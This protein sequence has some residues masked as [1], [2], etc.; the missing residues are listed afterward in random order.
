VGEHDD[1]LDRVTAIARRHGVAPEQV[2]EVAGGVANRGFVL[3]DALFLRV[4]RPG[5]EDDLRKEAGVVPVA[6]AAGVLTPA[7]LEY[8]DTRDAPYVVMERVHG[9]EPTEAPDG[10]AEQL[11]RLHL[12]E[13]T[14]IPGVPQ[15]D[16]DDPWRT[17]DDLAERGYLD[18]GTA[19]WL[20]G[21]FTRLA[22]RFDRNEAK[23]LI[24]GDVAAH[25]LLA[26][27]GGGE[28][29]ALI[30]WGDAA[31]APRGMD[32]AK[33]PLEHVAAILPEY[34]RISTT[35]GPSPQE[36][37]VAAAALWFHLDWGLGKLT[38]DPW[39]GQ[40]HWTAPP[41]SRILGLLRFFTTSPPTPWS[42]L[43]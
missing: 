22:D 25:N 40:R 1:F 42:T 32:F 28:L 4:A 39:P 9:I 23:V 35:G 33:L 34:I 20:S 43:T 21:W 29:R 37:E 26:E 10:L 27:P 41:A 6:R 8:S 12:T 15:D 24:H 36:D 38:A 3:G 11:A 14:D 7:I 30:D 13:R 17:V 19:K 5:F 18:F 2:T 31:W 16:R